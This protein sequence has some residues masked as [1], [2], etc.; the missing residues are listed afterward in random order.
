VLDAIHAK[1]AA[2][3]ALRASPPVAG[4]PA[5]VQSAAD[6]WR[7]HETS[8]R[9]R[10]KAAAASL[11]ADDRKLVDGEPDIGRQ[12]ALLAR[13]LRQTDAA[14]A[15]STAK[16]RAPG[17]PPSS[18]SVDF[19]AALKD[20]SA[21]ADAKARDPAGFAKFFSDLL[22]GSSRKPSIG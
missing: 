2:N 6:R 12:A 11:D 4:V 16:P 14:A 10:V 22:R 3:I 13:F 9:A 5:D 19:A 7:A 8:E 18:S 20:P 21:L 15:K 1:R 17:G